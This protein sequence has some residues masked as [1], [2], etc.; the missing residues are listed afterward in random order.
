MQTPPPVLAGLYVVAYA[1]A[2][3]DVIFEQRQTLNVDGQ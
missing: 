3:A 2:D 1:T